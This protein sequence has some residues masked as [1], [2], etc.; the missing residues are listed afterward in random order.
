MTERSAL[1]CVVRRIERAHLSGY[2]A[3]MK[4]HVMSDLH[5]SVAAFD[6]PRTEA[7]VVVLA[8][9]I[10]RPDQ[11]IAWA[12]AFDKPVLYVAGN[13]EFYGGSLPGT[14]ARMKEL[15][16]DSG[17]RV[18]DNE[19]KVIGGMRFIGSTLWTDFALIE[20]LEERELATA[21]AV[22]LVRDF[23][24]IRVDSAS[25]EIFSPRT[26][27]ALFARNAAWIDAR[28]A[29]PF[30]GPTA[31]ITHH[32]PSTRSIHPRFEDSPLNGCFVSKA[33][34]LLGGDRTRLWIHG[35]THD[36]FDYRLKGTRVV[37]NPRGYGKHG[38]NENRDFDPYL[39]I[40]VT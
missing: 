31:V 39:V 24:R 33:D 28:L 17:I 20:D 34:Y 25:D 3:R 27:A 6:P 19:V 8:G 10:A 30:D 38:V 37:C 32:A 26:S 11:A 40:D 4:L 12:R 16:Q 21:A 18:L 7:D 35:H 22:R 14:I 15:A 5:L 1:P 2:L 9:D 36:R 29:E 23:S 13:H